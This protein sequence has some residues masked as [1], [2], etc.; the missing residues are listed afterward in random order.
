MWYTGK[1]DPSTATGNSRRGKF[2]R[3]VSGKKE[4]GSLSSDSLSLSDEKKR[5]RR[6]R[7][8]D[9]SRDPFS[10]AAEDS[11]ETKRRSKKRI[12]FKLDNSDEDDS[13]DGSSAENLDGF[14]DGRRGRTASNGRGRRL[15]GDNGDDTGREGYDRGGKDGTS[16]LGGGNGLVDPAGSRSKLGRRSGRGGGADGL[17]SEGS[18]DLFS[19]GGGASTG[20]G[21]SGAG[22]HLGARLGEDGI[23]NG[24]GSGRFGT[25]NRRLRKGT[26]GGDGL[27]DELGSQVEVDG[28]D[29]RT[30][31]RT[32]NRGSGF[33]SG[34]THTG[35][36]SL[37]NG[38]KWGNN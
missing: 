24:T 7:G 26:Q 33:H 18:G 21:R 12:T 25:R 27:G 32:E 17:D 15:G 8:E 29:R 28:W 9:D 4:F 37:G 6:G 3:P 38:S 23:G 30:G 36:D 10:L 34:S 20:D 5:R 35:Q 11:E 14:G 31:T 13:Y 2:R 22:S 19:G 16:R 1:G